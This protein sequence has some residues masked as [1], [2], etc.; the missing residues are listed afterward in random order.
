MIPLVV[1]VVA[2][3]LHVSV[4]LYTLALK[5]LPYHNFGV[6]VYTIKLDGASRFVASS[7]RACTAIVPRANSFLNNCPV[8]QSIRNG[9][10]PT[11]LA[12][13]W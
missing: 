4:C 11:A 2:K 6:Y 9:S 7:G 13:L 10:S 5:G 12:G 8:A 3:R 1:N